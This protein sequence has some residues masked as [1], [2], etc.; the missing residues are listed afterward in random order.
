LLYLNDRKKVARNLHLIAHQS[1]KSQLYMNQLK[2]IEQ[3]IPP[4]PLQLKLD[5]EQSLQESSE[6]E[7][8][9]QLYWENFYT[10]QLNQFPPSQ[11]AA[12]IANEFK[13]H[14]LFID[15]GCGNGRDS[16]FFSYLGHDVIGVDKSSAAIEFC[17]SQMMNS[18]KTI[19]TFINSDVSDLEHHKSMFESTPLVKKVIYSRFFIHAI[20]EEREDELF[21]FIR[22]ICQ[23]PEDVVALE[24]RTEE[25]A[26][27]PKQAQ[28]HFRRFISPT[29]LIHK[30]QNIYKFQIQYQ[31]Q[32]YGMA[33]YGVEDAHVCRVIAK[34]TL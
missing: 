30:M 17:N 31:V 1:F 12:F 10:R 32:G 19:S 8:S 4:S 5:G 23:N 33:K 16:L 9:A 15:I 11:F 20:Q 27:N 2:P 26:L 3:V 22:R 18:N 25:D 29:N 24:F 14:P 7:K 34:P 6:L 28:A 21:E 13:N